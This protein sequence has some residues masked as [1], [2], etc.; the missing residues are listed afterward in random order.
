[1]DPTYHSFHW[2]LGLALAG[3]G[4][5]EEASEALRRATTLAPDEPIVSA[6]FCWTLARAGHR[7]EAAAIAD[8]LQRRQ[9]QQYV[10]GFSMAIVRLGLGDREQAISWLEQAA[11][12]RDALLPYINVHSFFDDLR[13]D[14]RFQALLQRMNFPQHP[15]S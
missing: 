2:V 15:Q 8:D 10:P 6:T 3:W 12:E 11:E 4:K 14:P 13:S 9:T 1:M 7:R 5:Y